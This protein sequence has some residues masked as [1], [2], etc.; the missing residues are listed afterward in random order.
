MV[1]GT[2]GTGFAFEVDEEIL[3]DIEFLELYVAWEKDGRGV[4]PLMDFVLGPEQKRALYEHHRNE[5]GYSPKEDVVAAF[6]EILTI[7]SA[8]PK[9]KN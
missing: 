2:T 8:D 9:T 1:K 6:R 4:F 5:R 7:V 3:N